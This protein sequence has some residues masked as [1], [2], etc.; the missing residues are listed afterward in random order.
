M[1]S[2]RLKKLRTVSP[3]PTN[4]SLRQLLADKMKA[5][6]TMV[7]KHSLQFLAEHNDKYSL[8]QQISMAS[9][10]SQVKLPQLR[11]AYKQVYVEMLRLKKGK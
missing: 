3:A 9:S 5:R 7:R 11:G 1:S 2:S 10:L 4:A 8:D 6:P